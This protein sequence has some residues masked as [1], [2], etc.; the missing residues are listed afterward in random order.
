[1]SSQGIIFANA[2]TL[3]TDTIGLQYHF[4]T[5]VMHL[6]G[7]S[8]QIWLTDNPAIP[9]STAA[10]TLALYGKQVAGSM[11]L[12]SV[13]TL[14][15]ERP[16]QR[17]VWDDTIY[18][19]MPTSSSP[20]ITVGG[21]HTD[22]GTFSSALPTVGNAYTTRRRGVYVTSSGTANLRAGIT[23]ADNTF[24]QNSTS[25][26]GGYFFFCRFGFDT[27]ATSVRYFVGLTA[28]ASTAI[29]SSNPTTQIN[30]VGFVI[31]DNQ[32]SW[33]FYHASTG[34]LG[35]SESFTG[36]TG[37][38]SGNGYDVYIYAPANSTRVYYRMDELNTGS[39]IVN[40]SVG[41]HLPNTT[42]FAK[43][44]AMCGNLN[45]SS[46][47]GRIGIIKMYVETTI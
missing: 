17:S 9:A 7:S 11:R 44:V 20:G 42:S 30:S 31:N 46:G 8:S 43:A 41:N 24:F 13:G 32:S 26:Y 45:T 39:T 29:G 6:A 5:Q 19:W 21:G 22:E 38:A 16:Y 37:A 36:Q 15:D 47:A 2:G 35:T 1:M 25:G 34:L 28:S 33:T 12:M 14:G 3:S 4:S 27:Y 18:L 23:S 40:S 10:S